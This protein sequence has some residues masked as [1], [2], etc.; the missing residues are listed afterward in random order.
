[1][2]VLQ[3]P[4]AGVIQRSLGRATGPV[5]SLMRV[6]SSLTLCQALGI[7]PQMRQVSSETSIHEVPSAVWGEGRDLGW[8]SR[9]RLRRP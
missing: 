8:R 5:S 6:A 1:M 3:E 9:G 4:C 7:K 2:E